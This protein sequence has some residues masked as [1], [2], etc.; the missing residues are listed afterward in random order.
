MNNGVSIRNDLTMAASSHPAWGYFEFMSVR[1]K[2]EDV[3][4]RFYG[5]VDATSDSLD[6]YSEEGWV[7]IPVDHDMVESLVNKHP[8]GMSWTPDYLSDHPCRD[9]RGAAVTLPL[10]IHDLKGP[11]L[12]RV[13]TF[14]RW[15]YEDDD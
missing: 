2:G 3:E 12:G 4:F 9:Y 7:N 15:E 11:N 5:A 14:W 13:D 10:V 1:Y 8:C 6:L